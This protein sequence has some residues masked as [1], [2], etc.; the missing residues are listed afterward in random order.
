MSGGS[1]DYAYEKV[2]NAVDA[3]RRHAETPLHYAFAKH[4]EKVSAALHDLEWTLSGDYGEGREIPAIEACISPTAVLEH[5]TGE[6]K[7]AIANLEV[8]LAKAHA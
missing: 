6:A 5:C 1:L 3:I 4:L 8:A 7:L 2:N